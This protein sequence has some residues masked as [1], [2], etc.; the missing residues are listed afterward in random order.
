[1]SKRMY[2]KALLFL[3]SC[4]FALGSCAVNNIEPGASS[5][6]DSS[7]Q[8]NYDSDWTPGDDA[9]ANNVQPEVKNP[10][11]SIN[12]LGKIRKSQDKNALPQSGQANI[13]VVP[14]EFKDAGKG[15]AYEDG[16]LDKIQTDYFGPSNGL[17]PSVSDYYSQSSFNKL[18]LS[19]VVTPEKIVLP[20]T[21]EEYG[22]LIA[23]SSQGKVFADI[24]TYVYNYLFN[25]TKT[26]YEQDFDSDDDGKV[27]NIA[28]VYKFDIYDS[29]LVNNLN[30]NQG[31]LISLATQFHNSLT[32]YEGDS[33]P[34]LNSYSW[35]NYDLSTREEN[36]SRYYVQQAGLALGLPSLD[37]ASG[38][39]SP[40]G[41]TTMM[42]AGY[43]DLDAFSKYQLGWIEPRKIKTSDINEDTVINLKDFESSG[44]TLLL[45][46]KDA[47]LFDEYLLVDYYT[48]DGLN[49][50][51]D[52][53]LNAN[54]IRITKVDARLV[55]GNATYSLYEGN[56]DFESET[57]D[58]K[59][60]KAK[61]VYDYAFTN[62]STNPYASYGIFQNY[63]LATIL[64]P[65]GI[66]RHMTSSIALNGDALFQVGDEFGKE[67]DIE[68][69]Y[70]NFAFDG[71][72]FDGPKLGLTF[73][74]DS[75]DS[76][77]VLTVRKA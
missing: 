28:L 13:L 60:D 30:S 52:N 54:G 33:T 26:Y 25:E 62:A 21:L 74:V 43:N 5:P 77:A 50:S 39:R 9:L 47:G 57:V 17:Y 24:S 68:G 19:G 70:H 55:R 66:N 12:D 22:T 11:G 53:T 32:S 31:K 15:L 40:M 27:D 67:S 16:D 6:T 34:A 42:D 71:N 51:S 3:F 58:F 59:G 72:G 61:Y 18:S 1:M 10:Q 14:V 45:S 75:L 2:K 44:E 48:R 29:N 35:V 38:T 8:D 37:D 4:S 7:K 69:F 65:E 36:G 63:A 56:L 76:E 20:H 41:G 49:V 64:D 46:Y 73:S 23:N